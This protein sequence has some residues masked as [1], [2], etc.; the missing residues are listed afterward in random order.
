MS[1]PA[2]ILAFT[3][4][5][6]R[7]DRALTRAFEL[8]RMHG[9]PVTMVSVLD[10]AMPQ[11]L[12]DPLRDK[13]MAELSRQADAEGKE[14]AHEIVLRVGDP[15]EELLT[16]AADHP[17]ALVVMGIHRPRPFL[18]ALRE[19]TMTRL[20]RRTGNP[21]LLVAGRPD[22][23]YASIVAAT[24]F[25][26]AST[27]ALRL[28]HALC[29]EAAMRV[30]HALHVPYS[31][32]LSHSGGRLSDIEK[33]FFKEAREHDA[34][35]RSDD[36]VPAGA[37]DTEIEVSSPFIWL[38]ALADAGEADLITVGAHGRVGAAPA[39]LGSLSIDLMRDPPCDILIA[40]P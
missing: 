4:M 7:S 24:D 40:R 25:S 2:K 18:D 37:G 5:S 39:L 10:D 21:V 34:R 35:W 15:T 9:L 12:T 23:P 28:A 26:P 30:V 33:A 3:D 6:A 38:K 13:A 14:V 11:D 31:G 22:Q 17:E 20:V 32:M 29:P 27:A 16:I 19:T 36:T 1:L 8:G